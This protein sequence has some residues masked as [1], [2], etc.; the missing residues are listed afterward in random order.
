M[1]PLMGPHRSNE[2]FQKKKKKATVAGYESDTIY[3]ITA[4][5]TVPP[6]TTS[7]QLE[8]FMVSKRH[9]DTDT[10]QWAFHIAGILAVIEQTLKIGLNGVRPEVQEGSTRLQTEHLIPKVFL[11]YS[12]TSI[13]CSVSNTGTHERTEEEWEE[14]E[15]RVVCFKEKYIFRLAEAFR[16]R[17]RN[18]ILK[19][20]LLV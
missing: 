14:L 10:D 5:Q 16:W 1:G 4:P 8:R 19:G 11:L 6:Q 13:T 12:L 17:R 3:G 18:M 7:E 2:Y 9:I 20:R 15:E